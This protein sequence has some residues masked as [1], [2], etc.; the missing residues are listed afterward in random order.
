MVYFL[1]T[2]DNA[3]NTVQ[4]I[5]Y[6]MWYIIIDDMIELVKELIVEGMIDNDDHIV[7]CGLLLARQASLEG[8]HLFPS[9]QKWLKVILG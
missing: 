9:Y 1:H 2:N 8:S 6:F 4:G 3:P 5:I 7:S